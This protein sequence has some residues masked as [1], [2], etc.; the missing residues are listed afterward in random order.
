M[1]G[2]KLSLQSY[3]YLSIYLSVCPVG[4]V[5]ATINIESLLPFSPFRPTILL[6]TFIE[7]PNWLWVHSN[8]MVHRWTDAV[9]VILN[10]SPSISPFLEDQKH[11]HALVL[12]LYWAKCCRQQCWSSKSLLLWFL[13]GAVYA[14]DQLCSSDIVSLLHYIC[15]LQL[16]MKQCVQTKYTL[17]PTLTMSHLFFYSSCQCAHTRIHWK[18]S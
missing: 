8:T 10:P 5:I 3:V 17:L 15:T 13:S 14:T 9:C 11:T 1:D 7:Q 6:H 2:W 4:N 12:M 18:S 16:H